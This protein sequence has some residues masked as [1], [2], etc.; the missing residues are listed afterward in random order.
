MGQPYSKTTDL[1]S[2][3]QQRPETSSAETAGKVPPNIQ[4]LEIA[5]P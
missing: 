4:K 2:H 1:S 3:F 5:T